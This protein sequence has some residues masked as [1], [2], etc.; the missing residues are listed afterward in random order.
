MEQI[1]EELLQVYNLSVDYF[2]KK[3]YSAFF[4]NIRPGI[5]YLSQFLIFDFLGN[6]E[7]AEDLINGD[8]SITKNRDDNSY[9]ISFY[10][11]NFRPTGRVFCELFPKAYFC[12]HRDVTSRYATDEKKRIKRGLDSCSA[13]MCRYYSIASEMGSHAGRSAMDAEVQAR[14]C[15]A[16]CMVFLD[17]I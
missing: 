3:E 8:T 1:K 12:K 6:E 10:P 13:E 7:E 16:F 5:E 11:A 2:N 15:A 17:Y 9:S 14:G 4:R